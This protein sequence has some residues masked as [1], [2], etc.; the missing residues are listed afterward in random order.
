MEGKAAGRGNFFAA[1][2]RCAE[3]ATQVGDG[4][5]PALGWCAGTAPT[6]S[7]LQ[8]HSCSARH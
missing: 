1:D 5:N 7:A 2:W 6:S 8:P 3:A 4:V